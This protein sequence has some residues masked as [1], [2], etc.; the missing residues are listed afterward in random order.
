MVKCHQ[1]HNTTKPHVWFQMLP[2]PTQQ[3]NL[4]LS[5]TPTWQSILLLHLVVTEVSFFFASDAMAQCNMLTCQ[6]QHQCMPHRLN[7]VC[8][9][10]SSY[11]NFWMPTPAPSNATIKHGLHTKLPSFSTL[12]A[13]KLPWHKNCL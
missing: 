9:M 5:L 11:S 1:S 7:F 8:F 4:P 6:C 3:P 13:K 12:G 10:F 2:T